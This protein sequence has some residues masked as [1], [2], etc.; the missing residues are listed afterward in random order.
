MC[1]TWNLAI[2]NFNEVLTGLLL[3]PIKVKFL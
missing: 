1:R 3:K 2:L